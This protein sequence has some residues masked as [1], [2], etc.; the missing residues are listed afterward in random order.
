MKIGIIGYGAIGQALY[1]AIDAGAAGALQCPAVL[2]RSQRTVDNVPLLTDP[3]AFLAQPLDVVVECAGHQAVRTLGAQILGQSDLLISSV[4]ALTDDALFDNLRATARAAGHK[5][6][7]PSAGI[8]ALDILSA[9]A[10]GQLDAVSITVRKNIEAWYGTPAEQLVA[11]ADVKHATT[12]YEGP[13]REGAKLYPGNV[14]ISAAVALAGIGLDRTRLRIIAD[15]AIE[16]HIIE[17]EAQGEFGRFQFMEDVLPAP[18]NPKTGRIVAMALLKT[19][20]QMTSELVI[21]V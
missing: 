21:G 17:V 14:N 6:I 9:A 16:T 19:L 13:V 5:L 10:V 12:L 18:D 15:P 3:A 20:R 2:V 11:L 7:I 8:G 1:A 4:G